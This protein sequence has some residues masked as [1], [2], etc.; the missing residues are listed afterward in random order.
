MHW[1]VKKIH[2]TCFIEIFTLLK[3]SET[4]SAIAPRHACNL[5]LLLIVT[6]LLFRVFLVNRGFR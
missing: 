2:V 5:S 4:E 1:K 6:E 3:W